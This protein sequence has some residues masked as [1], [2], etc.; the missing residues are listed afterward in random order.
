MRSS[1]QQA[2]EIVRNAGYREPPD[3]AAAC[4]L[5]LADNASTSPDDRERLHLSR[6]AKPTIYKRCVLLAGSVD[7]PLGMVQGF[8]VRIA[9]DLIV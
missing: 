9:H 5:S 4:Q 8:T 2:P 6:A 3:P 7:E 1:V